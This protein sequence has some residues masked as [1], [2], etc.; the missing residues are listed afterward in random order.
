MLEDALRAHALI[1]QCLVV[2]DAKPF[3]GA[4]ITLDP[5]ALPGWKERH[6]LAADTPIAE[7]VKHPDLVAEIDA[8]I[9]EGN[10][11]VSNPEQIKKY[12]ILEVDFT[13]DSGELTPTLKLKRNIIHEQHA[14]A[15][16][17]IYT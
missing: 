3:I 4:L 16:A 6:G 13:V 14:E 12:R 9:S 17:R 2:G 15:I 5:E 7:L 8:A 10:K 1:S 11:K